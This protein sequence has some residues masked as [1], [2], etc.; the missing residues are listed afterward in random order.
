MTPLF[1]SI[2]QYE[3]FPSLRDESS[4]ASFEKLP[5]DLCHVYRGISP[6]QCALGDRRAPLLC[7]E[8]LKSQEHY[9]LGKQFTIPFDKHD[10]LLIEVDGVRV[11]TENQ[12]ESGP[13]LR[14]CRQIPKHR[15]L[16]TVAVEFDHR[17]T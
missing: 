9:A 1:F 3:L 15:L 2:C 7:H 11:C 14:G 4:D 8:I 10:F 13:G 5:S 17:C 6:V 16:P 12:R